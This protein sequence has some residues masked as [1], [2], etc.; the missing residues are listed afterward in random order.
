MVDYLIRPEPIEYL[1]VIAFKHPWA[2]D[3]DMAQFTS[4]GVIDICLKRVSN[5]F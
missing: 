2:I 5:A 4:L 1:S 3:N